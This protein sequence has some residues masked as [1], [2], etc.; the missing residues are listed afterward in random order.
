MTKAILWDCNISKCY[1]ESN[2]LKVILLFYIYSTL[3]TI[4]G[5]MSML[6]LHGGENMG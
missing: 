4:K 3:L 1:A 5:I 2:F 6:G